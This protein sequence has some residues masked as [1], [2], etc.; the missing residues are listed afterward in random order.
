MNREYYQISRVRS[1]FRE[2]ARGMQGRQDLA[3][4]VQLNI[5]PETYIGGHPTNFGQISSTASG[6]RKVQL[7]LVCEF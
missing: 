6:P 2:P 4:K 3:M 7:S 1:L 5:Q